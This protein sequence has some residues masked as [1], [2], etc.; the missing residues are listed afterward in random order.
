MPQ[1][2]NAERSPFTGNMMQLALFM[3]LNLVALA[4]NT[5]VFWLCTSVLNAHVLYATLSAWVA[6][7]VVAYVVNR[8]L[9]FRKEPIG[10]LSTIREVV[11]FFAS[12]LEIDC[13]GWAVVW[14]LSEVV[15]LPNLPCV[16]ACEALVLLA[17]YF[18]DK[19]VVF[20]ADA[21]E[22]RSH[23]GLFRFTSD[24]MQAMI[25]FVGVGCLCALSITTVLV[26]VTFKPE[27]TIYSVTYL[28]PVVLGVIVWFAGAVAL[29]ALNMLPS[30]RTSAWIAF[31]VGLILSVLWVFI[32]NCGPAYDSWDL[33]AAAVAL[34]G[35]ENVPYAQ[36]N[37]VV[38]GFNSW[39]FDYSGDLLPQEAYLGR[40]PFQVPFVM[41]LHACQMVAGDN[42]ALFFQ[43]IN[44]LANGATFYL[45]CAISFELSKSRLASFVALGLCALA[46]SLIGYSTFIYGNLLSH[47]WVLGAWY[48]CLVGMRKG[49]STARRV[50][51]FC[52]AGVLLAVSSLIKSTMTI[53]SLAFAVTMVLFAMRY[54]S[55]WALPIILIPF[56][57]NTL[58]SSAM[59]STMEV[60][61]H[62]NL[63]EPPPK[64]TWVVMGLGGGQELVMEETGEESSL[65]HRRPGFYD[66]Y[67]WSSPF[68]DKFASWDE[69]NAYYLQR[70]IDRFMGDP[71][72]FV[73]F[74]SKKL[75][76][77][78]L[79]ATC[80]C[81][82]IS[83]Y[84][85]TDELA[86]LASRHRER[87]RLAPGF[88]E[89]PAHECCVVVAELSHALI[90]IGALVW[91]G[92][93]FANRWRVGSLHMF[94]LIFFLGTALLYVFWENKSQYLMPAWLII[95]P[96][97]ACGWK[98]LAAMVGRPRRKGAR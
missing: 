49:S 79:D 66:A 59:I 11:V 89:G 9:V 21:R 17:N 76:T 88:Y 69:Q 54:R 55:P 96:Y 51:L 61:M 23:V 12:R 13:I 3:L 42:F 45:V 19:R 63:H 85:S 32:A 60:Q 25:L 56:L 82:D 92:H 5:G 2:R 75:A 27:E 16:I 1:T 38:A 18:V 67:V 77:E 39:G 93:L 6:G 35:R 98:A 83:D 4:I 58:A 10:V 97:A 31:F 87:T 70:R 47:P 95:M 7:V 72:F 50:V 64:T 44:A 84:D 46:V 81:F 8:M 57:L 29:Y 78:W 90:A 74:L 68:P 33:S 20:V 94:G 24:C 62:T 71:A 53:A 28:F 22:H 34:F 40:F 73:E 91:C 48:A 80:E 30:Y 86:L 41:L 65:D 36:R 26:S 15:H 37:W 43:C 52:V 14:A